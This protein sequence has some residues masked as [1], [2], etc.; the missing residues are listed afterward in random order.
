MLKTTEETQDWPALII[1]AREG[2]NVALGQ[3]AAHVRD[4]L[5]LIANSGLGTRLQSK[6]DASDVVQY[7]MLDAQRGIANFQGSSEAE[8]RQWLKKIVI[9]NLTDEARKYTHTG[10]RNVHREV[11]I[12]SPS[13]ALQPSYDETPSWHFRRQEL[14]LKLMHAVQRLPWRQRFV[15]EA[16][17]RFGYSYSQIASQLR[18]SE[19]ATRKLWSRAAKQLR[20]W[21]GPTG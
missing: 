8:I 15:V 20:I 10:S 13:V 5:L 21:L 18:I 1:A 3:I 6:F 12:H 14:D 4:Y 11:S 16:R 17:H 7:S 9:H 19:G 2:C